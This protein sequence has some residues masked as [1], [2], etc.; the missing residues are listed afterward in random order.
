MKDDCVRAAHAFSTK[1]KFVKGNFKRNFNSS[2]GA[3]W[4][5]SNSSNSKGN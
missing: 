5:S 4:N 3:N 1:T 2:H